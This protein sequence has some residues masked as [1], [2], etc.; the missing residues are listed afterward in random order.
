VTS[1]FSAGF[2]AA[3]L[4]GPAAQVAGQIQ[5]LAEKKPEEAAPAA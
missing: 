4:T 3:A 1:V 5:T 2:S